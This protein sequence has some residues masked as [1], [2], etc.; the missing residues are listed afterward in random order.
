MIPIFE[1][2]IDGVDMGGRGEGAVQQI[3]ALLGAEIIGI[4]R[5]HFGEKAQRALGV[6]DQILGPFNGGLA[7]LHH[8]FV[9]DRYHAGG[10]LVV[11]VDQDEN[12]NW[13]TQPDEQQR[14]D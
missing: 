4:G 3:A 12:E 10:I 1:A 6:L 7:G 8:G 5:G 9:Q 14:H 13:D 2:D 11:I